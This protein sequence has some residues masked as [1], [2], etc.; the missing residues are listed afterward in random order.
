MEQG[1]LRYDWAS[2]SLEDINS[3]TWSSNFFCVLGRGG[4]EAPRVVRHKKMAM[5]PMGQGAKNHPSDEDQQRFSSQGPSYLRHNKRDPSLVEESPLL[6]TQTSRREQ[7]SW[8]WI[9]TRL[10]AKNNCAGEGLQQ[11]FSTDRPTRIVL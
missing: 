9:S 6:N 3:E 10:K 2:L 5:S 8:S 11:F 4:L 1:A 7:K